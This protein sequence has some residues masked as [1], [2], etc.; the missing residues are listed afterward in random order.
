MELMKAIRS[1]TLFKRGH[2]ASKATLLVFFKRVDNMHVLPFCKRTP[3]QN[4]PDNKGTRSNIAGQKTRRRTLLAV[5]LGGTVL[6]AIA[7]TLGLPA[8]GLA[9]YIAATLPFALFP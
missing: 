1:P 9:V 4:E 6:A 2:C 8:T 5:S 7:I 3:G